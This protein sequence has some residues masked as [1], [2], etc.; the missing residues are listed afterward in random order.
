MRKFLIS[1]D[2]C[3]GNLSTIIEALLISMFNVNLLLYC[4]SIPL[5]AEARVHIERYKLDLSLILYL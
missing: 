3:Q 1:F 2:F 4:D 5:L